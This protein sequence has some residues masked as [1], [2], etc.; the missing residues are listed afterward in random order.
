MKKIAATIL[1]ASMILSATACTKERPADTT[2]TT[3]TEVKTT[4]EETTEATE[5]TTTTA[6][7]TTQESHDV[8]VYE[9][10]RPMKILTLRSVQLLMNTDLRTGITDQNSYIMLARNMFRYW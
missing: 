9:A 7:E 6:E 5:A 3:T 10:D 1:L 2:A 8:E 4:T